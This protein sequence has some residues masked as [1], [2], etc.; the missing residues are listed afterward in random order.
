MELIVISDSR[1]KVILTQA[2][3]ENYHLDFV[4]DAYDNS[5][6]RRAIMRLFE[7]VKRRSGFDIADDRI[8][9]Q[10]WPS[11]EGGCELYVSKLEGKTA[12]TRRARAVSAKSD[13]MTL[14]TF[15]TLDDLLSV[16]RILV[17][18]QYNRSSGL[19][20]AESGQWY[21]LLD[22][23]DL[24]DEVNDMSFIEEYAGK[25]GS[26]LMQS[27]MLEHARELARGDAIQ[28]L[29]VLV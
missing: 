25:L 29:S 7:D 20:H 13:G 11:A 5:R 23:G 6:T 10:I 12:A 26:S 28:R 8:L 22:T 18:R 16:C 27:I 19:Y 24:S 17:A 21:L 1:L 9:V 4:G 3:M 14:Y 2:D 15:D